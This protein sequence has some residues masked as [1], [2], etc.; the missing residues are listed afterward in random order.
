MN[1]PNPNKKAIGRGEGIGVAEECVEGN[2][3]VK[4]ATMGFQKISYKQ[5]Y[6]DN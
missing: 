5:P 4:G 6:S 2:R 1:L 3:A